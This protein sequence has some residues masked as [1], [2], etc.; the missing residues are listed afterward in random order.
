MVGAAY[1]VD[2][3]A[4]R[5][6]DETGSGSTSDAVLAIQRAMDDGAVILS[7][8]WGSSAFSQA[9]GDI[10]EVASRRGILFVAAAG[11]DSH[12]NDVYMSYPANDNSTNVLTVCATDQNNNLAYFS[13]WGR[14]NV[15]ICAPGTRILSTYRRGYA[16][17]QGT[18]MATPLVA[19]IAALVKERNPK[20]TGQQIKQYLIE[21]AQ[22]VPALAGK[23]VSG[24][25]VQA[26]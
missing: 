26:P 17:L 6:L 14:N 3:R 18:S 23:S 4:Y 11:N 8:S 5:F 20:W 12:D 13:N 2:L 15:H 22:K 21:T 9:L 10:I 1:K 7:N 16:Y 25:I 19:G 24:G